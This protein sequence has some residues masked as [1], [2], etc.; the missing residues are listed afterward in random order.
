M[1]KSVINPEAVASLNDAIANIPVIKTNS[2]TGTTTASGNV[3]KAHTKRVIVLSAWTDGS[4]RIVTPF[5]GA[6]AGIT[7]QYTWW[8]QVFSDNTSHSVIANTSVTIYYA[9]I[10]TE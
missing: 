8:F 10:E 6:G 9:Y 2:F 3:S 4:D 1:S 5:P 7:G